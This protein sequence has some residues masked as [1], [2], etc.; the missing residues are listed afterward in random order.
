[1]RDTALAIVRY[2]ISGSVSPEQ[3]EAAAG[4]HIFESAEG[5]VRGDFG[6]VLAERRPND[7]LFPKRY[8][9][10]SGQLLF[11]SNRTYALTN[12]WTRTTV[13]AFAAKA[14]DKFSALSFRYYADRSFFLTA[15]YP[16]R[17][18]GIAGTKV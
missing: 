15:G 7:H 17:S 6:A 8:F 13:E 3:I 1:M 14:A 4:R 10:T 11:I 5:D 18:L 2:L 12:Q 9:V 16:I